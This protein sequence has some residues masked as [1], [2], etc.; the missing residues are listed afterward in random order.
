MLV[1]A[2]TV[3]TLPA[4][5]ASR[6]E[7]PYGVVDVDGGEVP[8]L[9]KF[10]YRYLVNDREPLVSGLV[11]GVR[12]VPGG[13]VLYY[14]IGV[15]SSEARFSPYFTSRDQERPYQ[16]SSV[17]SVALV[18]TA[19]LTAYRP[20]YDGD[21]TF[22]VDRND[23]GGSPGE[24]RVGWAVFPELPED[25]ASVQVLLTDNTSAGE[26]PVDD[27]VLEPTTDEASIVLGDG[28]PEVPQGSALAGADPAAVTFDLTRRSGSIDGSATIDETIDE[29]AVTLDANVLFDKESAALR[30]DA[31][32]ALADVAKDVAARGTGEVVVIGHTDSDGSDQSNQVLSEQRAASVVAALQGA[33]GGQ[34]TFRAEGRGETE[35]VAPNDTPENKQLNRRV[36]VTY[37][38]KAQ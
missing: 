13:T 11:H 4:A 14:S 35:P 31:Q 6:D 34:V 1:G 7:I 3:S 16:T 15:A 37:P 26:V 22:A 9:A 24:L 5:P 23:L 10:S 21:T 27:G 17:A 20:L 29:V 36:T 38:V 32:Q 33:S 8:V 19:N 2:L 18:D 25:V 28:W 30:P 12:R